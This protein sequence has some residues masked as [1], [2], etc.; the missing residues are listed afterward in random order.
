[1]DAVNFFNI[2]PC[3]IKT[4]QTI[5]LLLEYCEQTS[6]GSQKGNTLN[7]SRSQDHVSTNVVRSFRLAG[8]GVNSAFTDLSN[9]DTGTDRGKT[10][11]QCTI[12]GL[13]NISQEIHHHRHFLLILYL[14]KRLVN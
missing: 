3:R 10:C 13:N 6:N 7:Q 11:T 2:P 12:T 14:K 9:T 8:N 4:R 5:A 1:L